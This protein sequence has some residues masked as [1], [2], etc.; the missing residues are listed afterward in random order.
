M[1]ARNTTTTQIYMCTQICCIM[2]KKRGVIN[3][4]QLL[5][6]C[7]RESVHQFDF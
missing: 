1:L 3:I 5:H 4:S 6:S 7:M 2:R